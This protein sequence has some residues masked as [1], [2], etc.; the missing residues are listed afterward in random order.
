MASGRHRLDHLKRMLELGADMRFGGFDQIIQSS[1]RRIR[2]NPALSWPHGNAK[3]DSP[4]THL[5]AL[6]SSL[7]AGIRVDI[8]LLTVQKISGWGEVMHIG[9]WGEVMHIGGS[10][11][12]RM[13]EGALAIHADMDFHP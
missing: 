5:G 10:G 4:A 8:G 3:A 13:N 12:H 6:L 11:F 1:L 7:I 2:Q 9:G